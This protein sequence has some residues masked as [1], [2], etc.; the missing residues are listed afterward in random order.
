VNAELQRFEYADPPTVDPQ[1]TAQQRRDLGRLRRRDA[2]FDSALTVPGS[3]EDVWDA[4]RS[5]RL[6][7][8]PAIMVLA[9]GPRAIVVPTHLHGRR[10]WDFSTVDDM[11]PMSFETDLLAH[12]LR[13]AGSVKHRQQGH[14]VRALVSS[15]TQALHASL[16]QRRTDWMRFGITYSA[17]LNRSAL[18]KMSSASFNSFAAGMKNFINSS[19]Q[20]LRVGRLARWWGVGKEEVQDVLGPG[21][22]SEFAQYRETLSDADAG[23]LVDY[24]IISG[25]Q[26]P[27]GDVLVLLGGMRSSDMILLHAQAVAAS[28]FEGNW[29]LWRQGSDVQRVLVARATAPIMAWDLTGW[30]TAPDGSVG[31]VWSRLRWRPPL[32]ETNIRK[33]PAIAE[34]HAVVQGACLG[35]SHARTGDAWAI[36]GY[37]GKSDRFAKALVRAVSPGA[38]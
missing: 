29:G 33:D 17:S 23:A 15:Y 4:L 3:T 2:P 21:L 16:A 13:L 22:E 38:G 19:G 25:Y 37:L 30:S 9:V 1:M 20:S 5:R 6:D 31:R 18:A 7:H 27:H 24:R 26:S 8:S 11:L 12:A 14:V 32:K 10:L 35:L 34:R 28:P 36:A